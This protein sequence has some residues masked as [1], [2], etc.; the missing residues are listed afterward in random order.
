MLP[1]ARYVST[2]QA[3]PA[4]LSAPILSQVLILP[5][6]TTPSQEED[7]RVPLDVFVSNT[8]SALGLQ[9]SSD[10]LGKREGAFP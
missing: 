10:L 8:P 4:F 6:P 7:L 1:Y 9:F 5:V 3:A 2:A